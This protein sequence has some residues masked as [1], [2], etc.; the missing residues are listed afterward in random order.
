MLPRQAHS[1]A[2]HE[3]QP[4]PGL[5][6]KLPGRGE[7][8]AAMEALEAILGLLVAWGLT[9]PFTAAAGV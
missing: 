9:L 8:L 3:G 7:A 2:A 1:T 6:G 4:R 5:G